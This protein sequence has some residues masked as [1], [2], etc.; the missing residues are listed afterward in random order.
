M[1]LVLAFLVATFLLVFSGGVAHATSCAAPVFETS[2]ERADIVFIG[3][4]TKAGME[5]GSRVVFHVDR[6]FKGDVPT[7]VEIRT[8]GMKGAMIDAPGDYLV[9]AFRPSSG[10]TEL[11]AHLCGGTEHVE[12]VADW[13]QKLGPSHPPI[14]STKTTVASPTPAPVAPTPP[15]SSGGCASCTVGNA[16]AYSD[17]RHALLALTV[18][19]M[20][21]A[22]RT[23]QLSHSKH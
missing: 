14:A 20:F 7:D 3:R 15:A 23:R 16:P 21:Q 18:L 2:F 9:F 11:F 13:V 1:R 4:A 12:R 19:A 8:G 6:V 10:P 22:R 17:R 5:E